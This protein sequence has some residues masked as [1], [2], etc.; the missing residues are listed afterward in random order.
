MIFGDS[1]HKSGK[2]YA[3]VI[4]L[5]QKSNTFWQTARREN[6]QKGYG[7]ESYQWLH[8]CN[9]L[10]ENNR[11]EPAGNKGRNVLQNIGRNWL[12]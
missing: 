3:F 11:A 4:I 1:L 9:S 8:F 10:S 7:K 2:I 5:R 12:L 6:R